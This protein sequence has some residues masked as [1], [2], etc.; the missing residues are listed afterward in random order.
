MHLFFSLAARLPHSYNQTDNC[1]ITYCV[2]IFMKGVGYH[3]TFDIRLIISPLSLS[4][5]LSLSL[6]KYINKTKL[7]HLQPVTEALC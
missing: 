5:S 7:I 1:F 3:Q 6:N 4:L 2:F